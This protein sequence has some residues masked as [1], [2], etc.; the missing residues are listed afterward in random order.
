MDMGS[1]AKP[2][3]FLSIW[4]QGKLPLSSWA[5]S[6]PG[7]CLLWPLATTLSLS[8]GPH[9][10][11]MC[12]EL[13]LQLHP[14]ELSCILQIRQLEGRDVPPGSRTVPLL[15]SSQSWLVV[16]SPSPSYSV[17]LKITE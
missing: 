16:L 4:G 11:P 17:T 3:P 14:A 7:Q 12:P 1:L 10:A 5:M 2:V 9:S 6:Q 13:A 15:P 8:L